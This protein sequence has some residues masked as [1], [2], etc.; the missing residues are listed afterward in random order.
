MKSSLKV[1]KEREKLKTAGVS[2]ERFIRRRRFS[3]DA[4]K[5]SAQRLEYQIN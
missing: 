4:R 2:I 1:T 5:L 3:H